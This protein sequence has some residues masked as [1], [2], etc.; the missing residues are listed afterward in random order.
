MENISLCTGI[1]THIDSPGHFFE[2]KKLIHELT[3][4]ELRSFG[5]IINVRSKCKNNP[6]Y[7]LT[8]DDIR[9]W[10]KKYGIIPKNS[11]VCMRTGWDDKIDK[12]E[13][14]INL[15]KTAGILHFPGFSKE[16]AEFLCSE[17]ST[18]GIGIDTMS[19]DPGNNVE[20]AV[21]N[22]VLGN[23]KYMVENM[24]L[25]DLPYSGATI[26][27]IPPKVKDAHEMITRVIAII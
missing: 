9:E 7:E 23:N 1:G 20:L 4:D 12:P 5:V 18:N 21:H 19:L 8:V 2:G 10:E 11:L 14:F 6:D 27:C 24:I 25:R 15:D 16:S 3:L 17:R 26:M 22:I 13:D